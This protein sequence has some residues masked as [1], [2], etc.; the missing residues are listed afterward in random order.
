VLLERRDSK[1]ADIG[2]D[3]DID[4]DTGMDINNNRLSH[5]SHTIDIG[6]VHVEE[7]T[8]KTTQEDLVDNNIT[9]TSNEHLVDCFQEISNNSNEDTIQDEFLDND[10]ETFSL[11]SDFIQKHF[12]QDDLVAFSNDSFDHDNFNQEGV[13]QIDVSQNDVDQIE[14]E[15][16]DGMHYTVTFN[17]KRTGLEIVPEQGCP[18]VVGVA[19]ESEAEALGVKVGDHIININNHDVYCHDYAN[20]LSPVFYPRPTVIVFKKNHSR[21]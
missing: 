20:Y 19:T 17:S 11:D 16:D 3:T 1:H 10:L 9:L 4:T 8:H 12:N 15:Q 7:V 2:T 21:Y 5:S 13:S 14:N 18:T 6:H